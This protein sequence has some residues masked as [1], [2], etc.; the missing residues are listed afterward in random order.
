M[1]A[2]IKINSSASECYIALSFQLIQPN[3]QRSSCGCVW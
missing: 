2:V 3:C 1:M